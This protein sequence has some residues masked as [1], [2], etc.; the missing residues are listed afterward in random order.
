MHTVESTPGARQL[1]PSARSRPQEEAPWGNG[2]PHPASCG[3]DS[4]R[5]PRGR[6]PAWRRFDVLRA[7]LPAGLLRPCNPFWG[8]LSLWPPA[9]AHTWRLHY[10]QQ[11]LQQPQKWQRPE[12]VCTHGP[13]ARLPG[14]PR[15]IRGTRCVVET[16]WA[17]ALPEPRP[18]G[19]RR[20]G[21]GQGTERGAPG[22]SLGRAARANQSRAAT[23]E[24]DHVAFSALACPVCVA[25]VAIS[26]GSL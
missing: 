1:G 7:A 18:L 20:G 17:C 16:D 21:A 12:W 26:P 15:A 10:Q 25:P 23:A 19:L 5:G 3:G 4:G 2:R 11:Q 24:G 13:P 14:D 8:Q 6:F 22:S 9:C